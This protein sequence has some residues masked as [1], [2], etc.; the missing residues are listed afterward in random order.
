[1][2]GF[3]SVSV[4]FPT[5]SFSW[6]VGPIVKNFQDVVFLL[7][8]CFVFSGLFFPGRLMAIPLV[9]KMI[10]QGLRNL[11]IRHFSSPSPPHTALLTQ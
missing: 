3:K 1:M 10:L 11:S 6:E 7:N 9:F 8:I 4:R 5:Q 2:T